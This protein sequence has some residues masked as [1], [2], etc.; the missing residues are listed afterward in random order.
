[1]TEIGKNYTAQN[2]SWAFNPRNYKTVALYHLP[3]VAER[4]RVFLQRKINQTSTHLHLVG[5]SLGAHIAGTA[6]RTLK[7]CVNWSVDRITG[8]ITQ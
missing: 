4:L 3:K 6:A 5:Y 8:K 7:T 1:V 2:D